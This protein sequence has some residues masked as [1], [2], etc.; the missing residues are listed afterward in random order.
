MVLHLHILLYILLSFK[1]CR[2]NLRSIDNNPLARPEI[3]SPKTIGDRALAVNA[4][5]LL[6]HPMAIY[7]KDT[8]SGQY[9]NSDSFVPWRH[10]I[11]LD[12]STSRPH[13]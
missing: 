12:Q 8:F 7:S 1:Q 10:K 3:K 4:P 5:I 13:P 9:T 2:Y 11:F 6:S